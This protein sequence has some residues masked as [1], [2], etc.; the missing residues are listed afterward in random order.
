MCRKQ[1][2]QPIRADTTVS[3]V[4]TLLI[5]VKRVLIAFGDFKKYENVGDMQMFLLMERGRGLF[6]G[7]MY[8]T[9]SVSNFT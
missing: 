4:T 5:K 9:W 2:K 1:N 3:Y 6:S 8:S 7:A